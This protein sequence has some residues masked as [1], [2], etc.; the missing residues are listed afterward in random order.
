MFAVL[1]VELQP[2]FSG[3]GQ[4]FGTCLSICTAGISFPL[5]KTKFSHG[6]LVQ[7]Q[8]KFSDVNIDILTQ[9]FVSQN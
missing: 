3:V 5:R 2:I 4:F 6:L 9:N 8:I 7:F 1:F